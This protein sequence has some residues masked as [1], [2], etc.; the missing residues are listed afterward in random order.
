MNPSDIEKRLKQLKKPTLVYT[1]DLNDDSSP[2]LLSHIG[3]KPYIQTHEKY[4]VCKTCKEKM[5]FVCQL[6]IPKKDQYFLYVFYYCFHCC[7]TKGNAGFDMRIYQNPT[8][9]NCKRSRRQEFISYAEFYFEPSWSLPSWEVLESYDPTTYE[10]IQELYPEEPFEAYEQCRANLI[11]FDGIDF[12][13]Y[14]GGF[15]EFVKEVDVPI[16][17]CC[18][19]QMK[20]FLQLN[21]FE[22]F[23]MV[24]GNVGCLYLFTCEKQAANFQIVVQDF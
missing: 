9:K 7:S 2:N 3:G 15:P 8:M 17:S 4:P 11:E 12:L 24:W 23:S 5:N 13:A 10:M 19:K 16:C 18:Q 6:Y 20:L 14:Y 22:E 1:F 21:S